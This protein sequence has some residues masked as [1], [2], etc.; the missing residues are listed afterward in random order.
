MTTVFA[1]TVYWI[2]T[3]RPN[4]PWTAS[5]NRARELLGGARLVTTD[6]VLVEFLT[7]LSGGGERLREQAAKM[8]R[9]LLAHPG[10]DVI[11]QSHESF[12]R[13]LALYQ[14]R[15]DKDYSMT[16]C[17]SMDRMRE[18]SIS[19]VLT[20]DRHFSQEGFAVL[21]MPAA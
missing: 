5:A 18:H 10:V 16:D 15:P 12:L 14:T 9:A 21:M 19:A 17:I 1:D 3:V 2:A 20:N 13:G 11:P 4:D 8:A 6:E 7:A